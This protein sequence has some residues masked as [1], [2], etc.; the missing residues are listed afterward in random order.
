M[1][2]DYFGKKEYNNIIKKIFPLSKNALMFLLREKLNFESQKLKA[3]YSSFDGVDIDIVKNTAKNIKLNPYFEGV[4]K[5][6]R[7]YNNL[8]N[9]DYIPM[10][11]LSRDLKPFIEYY[12]EL[13][14]EFDNLRIHI[15][16]IRANEIDEKDNKLK[17]EPRIFIRSSN[18]H[19]LLDGIQELKPD[20]NIVYI[21]DND[22]KSLKGLDYII[23][24][25]KCS[26]I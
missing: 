17:G 4:V 10:S 24:V 23:R 14:N 5:N 26:G 18:K 11:F 25:Q 12:I 1:L 9:S 3:M 2:K 20:K 15:D 7:E 16:D 19:Y 13:N 8:D 22:E 6:I 21:T